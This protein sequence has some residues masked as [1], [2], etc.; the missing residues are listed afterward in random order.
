[1]TKSEQ[2]GKILQL[3]KVSDQI[4]FS[5]RVLAMWEIIDEFEYDLMR[6]KFDEMKQGL[7]IIKI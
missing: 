4:Y 6:K 1:M 2:L 7:P 3:E 5:M